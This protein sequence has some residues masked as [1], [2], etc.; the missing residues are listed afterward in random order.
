VSDFRQKNMI[1]AKA[2]RKTKWK[3][4]RYNEKKWKRKSD[5][6]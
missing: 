1:P 6:Q 3:I 2:Y 5:I 4:F